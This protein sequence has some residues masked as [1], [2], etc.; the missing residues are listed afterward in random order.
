[1]DISTGAGLGA[2]IG[3]FGLVKVLSTGSALIGA[4]MMAVFRPPATRKELFMQ[5]AVALGTSLIFG[6][7]AV[8]AAN[9]WLGWVTA[10]SSFEE[11]L[12]FNVAIHGLLGAF[13]WGGFG[14]LAVLRDKFSKDPV[15]AVKEIKDA[16]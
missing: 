11:I 16:L 5:A 10:A 12:H 14:G 2:L 8:T 7:F 1:M 3:K 4:G 13:A 15:E 9:H 6:G